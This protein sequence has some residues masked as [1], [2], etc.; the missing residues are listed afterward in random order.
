MDSGFQS[1]FLD[2]GVDFRISKWISAFLDF[3][4]NFWISNW[5]SA[6]GVRDFSRD[7]PLDLNGTSFPG[8]AQLSAACM[9]SLSRGIP[10]RLPPLTCRLSMRRISQR[11][12]T[13]QTS[14]KESVYKASAAV[15]PQALGECVSVES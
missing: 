14:G 10:R 4:L 12:S 2:F 1:G 9:L 7:G 15:R 6:D 11:L 3:R 5:I 13:L 8:P